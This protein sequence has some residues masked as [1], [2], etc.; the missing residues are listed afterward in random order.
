MEN[1]NAIYMIKEKAARAYRPLRLIFY[2]YR[3]NEY[4][5]DDGIN[6]AK[7]TFTHVMDGRP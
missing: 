2:F 4:F 6:Y 7:A 1:S 5:C 3:I